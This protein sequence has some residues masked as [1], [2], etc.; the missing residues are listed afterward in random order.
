MFW[1]YVHIMKGFPCGPSGKEPICQWGDIRDVGLIPGLWRSLGGGNGNP[2]QY[3]CLENPMDRGTVVLEK[4]LESPLDFKETQPFNPK[5]NQSWIFIGR[6][7]AEAE[8]PILWPHDVKNWL[9]GKEML[10]KIEGRRRWDGWIASPTQWT[11]VWASSGRWWRTGKP[12][13]LQSMW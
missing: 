7:H 1:N 11:W 5:G 8:T 10:G 13:V 3:S 4:K 2:L 6:T 9:I 12:G